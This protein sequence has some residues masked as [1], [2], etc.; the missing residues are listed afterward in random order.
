MATMACGKIG[1]ESR[2]ARARPSATAVSVRSRKCRWLW[3]GI[4]SSPSATSAAVRVICGPS[5]PRRT[6][7][8]PYGFG[9]G[10]NVGGIS[11]CRVNS[12]RKSRRMP[13]CQDARMALTASTISRIWATGRS[14]VAPYLCSMWGRICEPRPSRKRPLVSSWRSY[15]VWARCIGLRGIAIATLVIRSVS[16]T[17]AAA[18]SGTNTS[19]GP[20]N[21]KSP[22]T[23]AATSS[24]ARSAAASGRASSWTS[25]S[26]S[27]P[28]RVGGKD[29][30]AGRPDLAPRCDHPSELS[31]LLGHRSIPRS[32]K[33]STRS[34]TDSSVGRGA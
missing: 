20:S 22:S 29:V 3:N 32:R 14:Q 31:E 25:R 21:V 33:K 30:E 2:P 15:A 24:C 13:S 5:A 18:T 1:R 9:P 16:T 7:G 26:T 6:G 28:A 27:D 4:T 12:P 34:R 10:T 11:V 17:P 19:C 23:P 8:A